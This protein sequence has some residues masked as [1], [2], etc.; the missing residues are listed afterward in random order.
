MI[1]VGVTFAVILV[2]AAFVDWRTRRAGRRP[3]SAS[4]IGTQVRDA[5]RDMWRQRLRGTKFEQLFGDPSERQ[6]I[7]GER[8]YGES[9]PGVYAAPKKKRAHDDYRD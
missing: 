8:R 2:F 3:A 4:D 6:R 1:G 9:T 5:H 7:P